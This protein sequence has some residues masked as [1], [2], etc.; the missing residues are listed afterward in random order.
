M[1]KFFLLLTIL[2]SLILSATS[3]S[4]S[5]DWHKLN[6]DASFDISEGAFAGV[7][8]DVIIIA[9]GNTDNIGVYDINTCKKVASS[10]FEKT[11]GFGASVVWG[12]SLICIGGK[13]G[14]TYL[15]EVT[16]IVWDNEKKG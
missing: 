3:Y 1:I 8:E 7:C 16:Q 4:Q 15:S 6:E 12:N 9:G 11:M 13:S 10:R 2:L 5:L 14:G